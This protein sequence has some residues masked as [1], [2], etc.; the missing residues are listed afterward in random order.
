MGK[1][2]GTD[3][4]RGKAEMFSTEF[5]QLVAKGILES[6]KPKQHDELKILIGGD[7]RESTEWILRDFEKAFETLGIEYGNAGVMPT[8][9]INEVF[10]KI[11][12]D[13]AVDVTASHNPSSDNGIKIFERGKNSG[14]KLCDSSKN[15]IESVIDQN[16]I[17]DLST[18][19]IREDLHNEALDVYL[20]HLRNYLGQVNLE[21]LKIGLDCANGATSVVGGKLFEEFG[22]EVHLINSDDRYGHVINLDSGSTHPEGLQ[23]LVKDEKL[24]FGAAFD[25]DGDRCMMVDH[26]GNLIDGDQIIVILANYLK[27]SKIAVTVMANQGLLEWAKDNNVEVTITPVGDQNVAEAMSKENIKI[28]GEQSGHIIL[29]DRS[30]G[31]GMLTALMVAKAISDSKSSLSE[32]A[33]TMQKFPQVIYNL[34]ADKLAKANLKNEK[35]QKILDDYEE[36]LHGMGGRMLVRPSGTE[37]LIRITMWGKNEEEIKEMANELAQKL[38]EVL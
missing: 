13:Y 3:G 23:K 32:L 4:I 12:F 18:T 1:Y 36:A 5:V 33:S 37:D 34:P 10:Y 31:D 20:D 28:G 30:M 2:F 25:G 7:T 16:Q 38:E 8:P 26:D 27:L 35:A 15:V 29:P 19:E 21:G 11:G 9:A 22:A 24:D 6:K 17:Y 14:V